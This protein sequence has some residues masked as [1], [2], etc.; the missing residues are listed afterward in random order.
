MRYPV[1]LLLVAS[2]AFCA[3]E[4]P[5]QRPKIPDEFRPLVELARSAPPEFGADALLRLVASGK[6]RQR[7]LSLDLLQEAFETA[8]RAQHPVRM[9]RMQGLPPDTHASYVFGAGQVKLDALSLQCRAVGLMLS[10]D[11]RKAR[12]LF[13]AIR[14]PVLDPVRCDQALI[15]DVS[16]LYSLL[17]RTVSSACTAE[18][19][20]REENVQFLFQYLDALSSPVELAPMAQALVSATLTPAQL[21]LAVAT[22]A[23]KL[24]LISGDDRSFSATVNELRDGIEALARQ[25][26]AQAVGLEALTRAFRKYL[27]TNLTGPR[28]EDSMD[29]SPSQAVDWFNREFR[30]DVPA[31]ASEETQTGKREGRYEG[32]KYFQSPIAKRL[33]ED[34]RTLRFDP[35][36]QARSAADRSSVEWRNKLAGVFDR[37]NAWSPADEDST[38]D[39]FHEKAILLQA[40]YEMA[41]AGEERDGILDSFVDLLNGSSLQQQDH[42]EWFWHAWLLH[43]SSMSLPGETAKVLAAFRSSG[44]LVL[45]L[46]AMEEQMFPAPM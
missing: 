6:L 28:C 36:G 27:V 37:L 40:L 23:S 7:D 41:P 34:V 22:L 20:R 16:P 44:N 5:K 4:K 2:L 18:E 46:Y 8:G 35:L 11:P 31:I 15:P 9:V 26:N 39:Y 3:G 43:N 13:E 17:A 32:H 1:F 45:S 14:K 12:E 33:N 21:Q 10:L 29:S 24:E 42:V 38:A 25:A 30:G 19:K